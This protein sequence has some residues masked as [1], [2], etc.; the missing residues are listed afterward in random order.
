M[1]IN[2]DEIRLLSKRIKKLE[3]EKTSQKDSKNEERII[4][5]ITQTEER[6]KIVDTKAAIIL[7]F[8]GILLSC[9]SF[10]KTLITNNDINHFLLYIF[11]FL[12][13]TSTIFLILAIRPVTK[14]LSFFGFSK[15][16]K[17]S[18][19]FWITKIEDINNFNLMEISNPVKAFEEMFKE[20]TKRRI[21]KYRLFRIA[22]WLLRLAFFLITLAVLVFIFS[23]QNM[24]S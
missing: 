8:Y 18:N 19:G 9:A 11:F 1:M 2:K 15:N 7:A 13:L 23:K 5:L 16:K 20:L 6:I 3:K 24:L 14:F 10:F 4:F 21:L 22:M 12:I 17:N